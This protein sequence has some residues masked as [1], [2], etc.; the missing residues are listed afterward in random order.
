[1]VVS[2]EEYVAIVLVFPFLFCFH[3]LPIKICNITASFSF[4]SLLK[5][6]P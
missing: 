3:K 2:K 5:I 6:K 4:R 1:M